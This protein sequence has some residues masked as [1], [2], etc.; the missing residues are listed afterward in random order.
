M[1][2]L[3][4]AAAAFPAVSP[5]WAALPAW[6]A[7]LLL[8]RRLPRA[9]VVQLSGMLA[10][11]G[12]CIAWA[13]WKGY[14]LE[15]TRLVS[16]NIHV[17]ALIAAVTFLRLATRPAAQAAAPPKGRKALVKTAWGLHLFSSAIN[18]SAVM[19][20]GNRMEQAGKIGRVQ[21]ILLS[22]A[23]CNGCYWSPFYVSIATALA[24]A[25][26]ADFL[27]LVLA[28]LPVALAGLVVTT[29]QLWRDAESREAHGCPLRFQ[30]L[31]VPLALSLAVILLNQLF[32]D[33]PV[34]TLIT[35]LALLL[36]PAV[37]AV[38]EPAAAIRRVASHVATGLPEIYREL[39]L[40]L[41]AG[42]MSAGISTVLGGGHVSLELAGVSP[43]LAG[44]FISGAMLL[45]LAGVH[46]LITISILGGLLAHTDYNAN[47]LGLCMMMMWA[48]GIVASPFSGI[49]LAL[50]GR[51]GTSSF[52]IMRWNAGY[53]LTMLAV[54][55]AALHLYH[56]LGAL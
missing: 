48:N 17:I 24:Y 27:T 16:A 1:T 15:F 49:N 50:Q 34:L 42:V 41:A 44:G 3:A 56:R 4:V 25:P 52:A 13:A 14:P 37:L 43:A 40:F 2:L 8:A 33:F 22:R 28:G 29:R 45:S 39:M 12:G 54:C 53:A 26:G 23:F 19:I 47:L 38:R 55:V 6:A 51:F 21:L 7:A 31:S 32:P 18:L 30:D 5:A 36:T 46:P 20:F 11:G 9:M 35:I 10:V